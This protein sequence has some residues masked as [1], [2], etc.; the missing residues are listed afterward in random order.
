L[1]YLLDL[2]DVYL[3]DSIDVYLLDSINVYLLDLIDVYLLNSIDVLPRGRR[4]MRPD[5]QGERQIDERERELK[6]NH[7][8]LTE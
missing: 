2:I 5:A 4:A 8:L 3:L 6:T 7:A 1:L